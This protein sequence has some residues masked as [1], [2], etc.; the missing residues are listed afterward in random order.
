MCSE[1]NINVKQ[2]T[3]AWYVDDNK[4]SH[5]DSRVIDELLGAIKKHFGEIKITRGKKHTF[6]GMNIQL[7]EDTKNLNQY[8]RSTDGG[9]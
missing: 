3:I 6:L 4:A 8:G 1:K 9:H 5:V 7:T 2:C